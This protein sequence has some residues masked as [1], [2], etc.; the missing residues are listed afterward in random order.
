MKKV[1]TSSPRSTRWFAVKA[2]ED[3]RG[4]AAVEFALL[5]PVML[6]LLGG[7]ADFALAFWNKGMLA[8][9]V[10][11]G[12]EYAVIVGPNVS[13]PSIQSIVMRKL[14]LPA[15]DVTITGP[16]CYC[17]SGTPGAAASQV[18][19]SPCPDTRMPSIYVKISAK[20]TYTPIMPYYSQMTDDILMETTMARLK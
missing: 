15:S 5:M 14:S 13:A 17:V 10:A 19:A 16:A 18:C 12:A 20:Y 1:L 11:A 7:L 4:V 2:A 9:A 6:L 8:S 3:Q